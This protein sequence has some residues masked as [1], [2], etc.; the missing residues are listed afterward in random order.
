DE[1]R[2]I[3]IPF[4]VIDEEGDL[5]EVILQWRHEDEEFPSLDN[6]GDGKIENAEVDEILADPILRQERHICTPYPHFAHGL[7]EPIDEDTVRL[8]ELARSESWILTS[9][10]VGRTLELLRPSSIPSPITP[11]W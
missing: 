7:V 9:G 2:G 10:I 4:R 8:P 6:D 1:R 3:P 5:V 11:T